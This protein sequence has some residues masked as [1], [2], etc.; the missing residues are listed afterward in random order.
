[1]GFISRCKTSGAFFDYEDRVFKPAFL[2]GVADCRR[3]GVSEP[4][5]FCE[6]T[7]AC[8][9]RR[10]PNFATPND[11]ARVFKYWCTQKVQ[12]GVELLNW[13]IAVFFV[14]KFYEIV[15]GER[16][17]QWRTVLAGIERADGGKL[18]NSL[19]QQQNPRSYDRLVKRWGV[20][21]FDPSLHHSVNAP[22]ELT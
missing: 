17:A 7:W 1:M 3:L 11:G 21:P 4:F 18:F 15:Q 6:A 14:P 12:E 22:R 10:N 16:L 8:V 9:I 20:P 19:F 5:D 2:E 13:S